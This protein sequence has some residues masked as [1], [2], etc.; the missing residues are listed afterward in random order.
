MAVCCQEYSL[1]SSEFAYRSLAPASARSRRADGPVRATKAGEVEHQRLALW[2]QA[3]RWLRPGLVEEVRERSEIGSGCAELG[4]DIAFVA[5]P[6]AR[7]V[8]LGK[9]GGMAACGAAVGDGVEEGCHAVERVGLE[10]LERVGEGVCAQAFGCCV[11][12]GPVRRQKAWG[13]LVEPTVGPMARLYRTADLPI[14][15]GNAG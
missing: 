10:A 15:C 7:P 13:Q 2:W 3:G 4:V 11:E 9:G 8:N 12:A 5:A 14:N 6:N 1:G